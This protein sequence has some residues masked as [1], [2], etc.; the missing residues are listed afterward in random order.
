MQYLGGKHNIAKQICVFLESQ[1]APGQI[2][3]DAMCGGCSII[4]RMQFPKIGM[5]VHVPLIALLSALSEG[6]F[7]CPDAITEEQYA[8]AKL[9]PDEYPLKAFIGYGCSFGGKYFGGFARGTEGRNYALNAKNSLQKKFAS[10]QDVQFLV[11]DFLQLEVRGALIYCDPPYANTTK[12][13]MQFDHVAFWEKVRKLSATNAVFVSEYSAPEDFA[14][15]LE[16]ERRLELQ[17]ND[18]QMRKEKLFQFCG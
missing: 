12:Y 14:C 2:F 6:T 1:R 15:K 3:I 13:S 9:L 10:L 7:E 17:S 11:Q 18:C 16:I 4:S 5:D 8:T